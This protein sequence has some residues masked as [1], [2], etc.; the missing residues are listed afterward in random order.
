VPSLRPYGFFV[1]PDNKIVVVDPATRQ[2]V[3]I[4]SQ[5]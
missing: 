2:V 4:I 3:R 5:Q 1:S